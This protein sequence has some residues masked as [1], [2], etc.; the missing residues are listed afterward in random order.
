MEPLETPGFGIRDAARRLGV[1]RTTLYEWLH[2]GKVR[3][4]KN[5]V[6]KL[7]I[8]REELYYQMRLRDSR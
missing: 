2:I 7:E 3:A 4:R 8:S 5:A 1:S 6:G